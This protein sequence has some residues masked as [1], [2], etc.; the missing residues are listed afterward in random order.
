MPPWAV[1]W[2]WQLLGQAG[3]LLTVRLQVRAGPDCYRL[4]HQTTALPLTY[5]LPAVP[6][7]HGPGGHHAHTP[8]KWPHTS[9][10]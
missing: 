6:G 5:L 4:N 1:V 10:H 9:P 7:A 8:A 3:G 2:G